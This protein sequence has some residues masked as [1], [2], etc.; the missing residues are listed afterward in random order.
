MRGAIPQLRQY[1][2]MTWCLAKHR[3]NFTFTFKP[4]QRIKEANVSE[5]MDLKHFLE[6]TVKSDTKRTGN[7]W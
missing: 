3:D 6:K 4:K 1:V 2:L 7:R 5:E